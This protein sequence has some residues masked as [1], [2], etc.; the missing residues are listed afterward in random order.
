MH[1]HEQEASHIHCKPAP[2][3]GQAVAGLHQRAHAPIAIGLEPPPAPAS[4]VRPFTPTR[5]HPLCVL[6][7]RPVARLL[8]CPPRGGPHVAASC[9][10]RLTPCAFAVALARSRTTQHHTHAHTC[11]V[12]CQACTPL[13]SGWPRPSLQTPTEE[14]CTWRDTIVPER[15]LRARRPSCPQ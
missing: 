3:P 13:Q 2:A 6:H 10:S 8:L 11:T 4:A 15:H 7:T 9:V 12:N 14:H 5:A 1:T